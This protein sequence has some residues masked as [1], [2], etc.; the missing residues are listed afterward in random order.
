[1]KKNMISIA[2]IAIS[3]TLATNSSAQKDS[4]G[5]YKTADDFK[6]KKLSF[7]INYRTEKHMIKDN[8]LFHG[9]EIKVVHEGQT[10]KLDKNRTYGYKSSKGEVFRFVGDKE[11]KVLNPG[12][13]LMLYDYTHPS[14]ATKGNFH[15]ISDYYFCTD[16]SSTPQ[17]LTKENLKK[18]FPNNHK[19]HDELDAT[20]N[21]DEGLA[22]Y[23][24]FHKMYK[25]NHILGMSGN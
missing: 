19:F 18:A 7:A 16:A 24:N 3:F 25:L 2:V 12:E 20:F 14:S 9:A 13:S 6:Q 11:Y 22:S 17:A 8:I 15:F 5:I 21:N 1:M 4:S 23:D 10:Y